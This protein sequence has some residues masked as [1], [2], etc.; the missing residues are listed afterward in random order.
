MCT[1]IVY[2][3]IAVTKLSGC[4]SFSSLVFRCSC[5]V[6]HSRTTID[7][8]SSAFLLLLDAPP[9]VVLCGGN[10]IMQSL[11]S[12]LRDTHHPSDSYTTPQAAAA[13]LCNDQCRPPR[14]HSAHTQTHT[15]KQST[16]TDIKCTCT[17]THNACSCVTSA[18]NIL[19]ALP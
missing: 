12:S 1:L 4:I 15:R 6:V 11:C 9:L 18:K 10:E 8:S 16:Y 7:L 2:V 14:T 5:S 3:C 13:A 19:Y 17:P